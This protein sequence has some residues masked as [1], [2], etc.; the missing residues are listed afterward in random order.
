MTKFEIALREKILTTI[1]NLDGGTVGIGR[2]CLWQIVSKGASSLPGAPV[3]TLKHLRAELLR[4][5]A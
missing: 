1:A 4:R 5:E 2:D 3:E